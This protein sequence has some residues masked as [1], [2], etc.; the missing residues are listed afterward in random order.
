MAS[1]KPVTR[2]SNAKGAP[3][4][5]VKVSPNV[6]VVAAKR[7]RDTISAQEQARLKSINKPAKTTAKTAKANTKA[8]KASGTTPKNAKPTM[9]TVYG[10]KGT[11]KVPARKLAQQESEK[12]VSAR[13]RAGIPRGGSLGTIGGG[14]MNWDTK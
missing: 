12:R 9:Y 4:M 8:L 14:G 13:S 11:T 5:T 6:T 2:S 1:P 3:K 10:P 7:G